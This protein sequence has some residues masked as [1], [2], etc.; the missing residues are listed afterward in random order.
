M[1]TQMAVKTA[2]CL[3]KATCL[4]QL[5]HITDKSDNA[6]E[7]FMNHH[8]SSRKTHDIYTMPA[9]QCDVPI[10]RKVKHA[11]RTPMDIM[12]CHWVRLA[13]PGLSKQG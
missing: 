11:P 12:M 5:G 8:N 4:C 10:A 2:D 7:R 6:A 3:Q 9:S 1:I 13:F